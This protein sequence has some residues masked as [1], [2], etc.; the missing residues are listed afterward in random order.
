MNSER[1]KGKSLLCFPEDY[2]VID[3]ETTGLSSEHN[4]IIELSA[5][6][7]KND[8]RVDEFSMLIKPSAKVKSF[9]THLTGITNDM[10]KSAPVIT[11]ILPEF[12][13]FVSDDVVIG[14]NVNFDINFI[15]DKMKWHFD[16]EFNNDFIDTLRL[17]R[18]HCPLKSHKLNLVAEY[19]DISSE[20]HHRGLTD[21]VMTYEIYK[22][23]K[24]IACQKSAL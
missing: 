17:S 24:D 10:L 21:C 4:E 2:T 5:I 11:D 16:K 15:Y 12:I 6:K 13:D 18:M 20:G 22:C 7:V 1:N 8:E 14:H 19:F 3:I 23:I 9:I